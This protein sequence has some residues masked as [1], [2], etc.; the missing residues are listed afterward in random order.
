M[1]KTLRLIGVALFAMVFCLSLAACSDDNDDDDYIDPT[2]FVDQDNALVGTWHYTSSGNGW[3]D[4]ESITFYANGTYSEQEEEVDRKGT[5]TSWEK[6]TWNTNRTKTQILFT[7]TDSSDR[8]EIGDRDVENYVINA[9]K[10]TIDNKTYT[11]MQ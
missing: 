5:E 2:G 4:I 6:G 10:L 8:R 7:V 11:R 3:S 9:D 1:K